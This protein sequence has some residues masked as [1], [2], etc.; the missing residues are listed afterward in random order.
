MIGIIEKWSK[1][2]DSIDDILD[3]LEMIDKV[4]DCKI[5]LSEMRY[6]LANMGN[7]MSTEE[8]D[9]FMSVAASDDLIVI[10]ELV[11]MLSGKCEVSESELA[12]IAY[13]KYLLLSKSLN[14]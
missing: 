2:A 13:F 12:I 14:T 8:V 10:D 9:G 4:N 11:K 7:M 3:A 6:A 1:A 5:T